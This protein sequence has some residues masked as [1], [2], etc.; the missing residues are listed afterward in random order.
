MVGKVKLYELDDVIITLEI[1]IAGMSHGD[2][3]ENKYFYS[4]RRRQNRN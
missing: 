2:N 3:G 4:K 1:H